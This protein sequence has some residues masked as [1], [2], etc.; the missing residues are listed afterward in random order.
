PESCAEAVAACLLR[1]TPQPVPTLAEPT[2][3]ALDAFEAGRVNGF[4][5]RRAADFFGALGVP[6]AKALAIPDAKRVA[7]AVNEIG[8]P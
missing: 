5:E 1:P 4:D 2:R 7:A 8:A 6:L 3:Q